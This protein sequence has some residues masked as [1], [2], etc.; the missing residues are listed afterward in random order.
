MKARQGL[1]ITLCSFLISLFCFYSHVR[2][3]SQRVNGRGGVFE[4][5]Q[6]FL[7]CAARNAST[8]E[9]FAALEK[10]CSTYWP[11]VYTYLRRRG[12]SHED[13]QDL[14]QGF[15]FHL[16]D[17]NFLRYISPQAGRFRNYL[18]SSLNNFVTNEWQKTQAV[19]RGGKVVVPLTDDHL[20]AEAHENLT[21]DQAFEQRWAMTVLT[22]ALTQLDS[23][24]EAT[25]RPDLYHALK[26]HLTGS[27]RPDY[28]ELSERL[29]TS[30]GALRVA[31]HRL[32]TRLGSLIRLLVEQTLRDPADIDEEIRYLASLLR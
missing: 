31:L 24:G 13:A 14:T 23:I 16:L 30:E 32:R 1:C 21:P 6:W 5:T 18:L 11:P 9:G 8:P 22:R 28:R 4:P 15:F 17:G 2:S 25:G 26:P 12:A 7:V 10:L 19:K 29:G 3:E 20:P 27:L